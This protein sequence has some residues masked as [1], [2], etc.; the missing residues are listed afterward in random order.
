MTLTVI[1][2]VMVA[3]LLTMMGKGNNRQV[4]TK[5]DGEG[6]M[7]MSFSSDSHYQYELTA[8]RAYR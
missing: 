7:R 6:V 8:V 4:E 1:V 3:L 2:R 5:I